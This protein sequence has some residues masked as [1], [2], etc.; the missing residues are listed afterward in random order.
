MPISA[1]YARSL[2]EDLTHSATVPLDPDELIAMPRLRH[3]GHVVLGD[4]AV[5]CYKHK[6]RWTYDERDIRRA[7]RTLA[8]LPLVLDDVVELHLPAYRDQGEPGDR[9]LPDWRRELVAW[10][11]H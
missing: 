6:A 2:F 4:I 9:Q 8:E 1:Q 11:F 3:H 5:R 7:A 10:M